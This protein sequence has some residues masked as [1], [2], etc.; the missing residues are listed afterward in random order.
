MYVPLCTRVTIDL[1]FI[2]RRR[3]LHGYMHAYTA[4]R[5]N[6]VKH[7]N[8]ELQVRRE[9]NAKIKFGL[10]FRGPADNTPCNTPLRYNFRPVNTRGLSNTYRYSAG[11]DIDTMFYSETCIYVDTVLSTNGRE[12]HPRK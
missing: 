12:R 5:E 2:L 7:N 11:H 10:T 4:Y 9:I 1:C 6:G 8:R 3:L